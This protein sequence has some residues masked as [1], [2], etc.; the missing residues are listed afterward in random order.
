M[1]DHTDITFQGGSWSNGTWERR[2]SFKSVQSSETM[3]LF[4]R[5][6]MT[7]WRDAQN[8][9][10]VIVGDGW[11]QPKRMIDVMHGRDR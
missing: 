2:Y 7:S 10:W 3:R 9:E 11:G 5:N 8:V 1:T 6:G 4:Y